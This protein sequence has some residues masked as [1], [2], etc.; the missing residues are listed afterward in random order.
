MML[1][2]NDLVKAI[3]KTAQEA[4]Q[5]SRPT[6]VCYGTVESL[7]PLSIRLDQ[8]LLLPAKQILL[9]QPLTERIPDESILLNR[10]S[11]G[12]QVI[13]LRAQGGQKYVLLGRISL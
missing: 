13:L 9:P 1:D 12:D 5:A 6:D 2:M 10:L 11:A 7:S 4:V 8:K 3:K